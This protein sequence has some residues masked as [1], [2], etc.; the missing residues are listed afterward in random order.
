MAERLEQYDKLNVERLVY[1]KSKTE[2]II[3]S[4]ED[5]VVLIDS[6]GI[7]AHINEIAVADPRRRCRRTRSAVRST[8]SA[9]TI[10]ITCVFATRL[11]TLQRA[12]RRRP[13]HRDGSSRSRPRSFLRAEAGPAASYGRQ[14]ARHA[15]DSAGRNLHSRSG[16]R[17]HQPGRDAV[18]RARTPLTSLALSAELLQPREEPVANPKSASCCKSILEECSRMRQLTDNLLNLARGED[19]RNRRPAKAARPRAAG[20]GRDP[21][22]RNPG[23]RETHHPRGTHRIGAGDYRRPGQA[24]VGDFKP[25]RQR[26][27]LHAGGRNDHRRGA[28][29]PNARRGWKSPIRVPAFRPT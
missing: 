16:S 10:L 14:V 2:A 12:G 9:A 17:A 27:A 29:A 7:V 21:A 20:G 25:D 15:A 6:D 26:A 19:S 24:L 13:S 8:I 23:A 3:E 22:L 5:G 4:L 1:E 11:R 28:S 18:A